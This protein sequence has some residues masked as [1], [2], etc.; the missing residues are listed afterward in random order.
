MSVSSLQTY[1]LSCHCRVLIANIR[2]LGQC[3]CPRCLIPKIQVQD[4]ATDSDILQR[5]ILA[6]CDTMERREKISAARRLIYEAQYVVD[7]PQVENLLKPE[8]LVP[9]VVRV[10]WDRELK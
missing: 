3:P 8:S 6:R 7:T 2:N 10:Q 5:S 4:V 9:T 1:L